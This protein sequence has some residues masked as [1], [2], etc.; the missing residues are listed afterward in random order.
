MSGPNR[1]FII[2][3]IFNFIIDIPETSPTGHR[4]IENGYLICRLDRG[5]LARGTAAW[6]GYNV[7][8]GCAIA[9]R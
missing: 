3:E 9:G 8:I 7:C 5:I 6:A 1:F 2:V 4:G